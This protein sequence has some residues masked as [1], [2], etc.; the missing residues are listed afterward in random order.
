[1]H[2]N[3]QFFLVC[4]VWV[5]I[6]S[7]LSGTMR[8][9][10][11]MYPEKRLLQ[12]ETP[13]RGSFGEQIIA[14]TVLDLQTINPCINADDFTTR[15]LS[16]V[17]DSLAYIN[18]TSG[19][20]E[21]AIATTWQS[22]D[23]FI[24][25][26]QLDSN[27]KWHDGT[28][29]SADDVVFSYNFILNPDAPLRQSE[30]Y[31]L[32]KWERIPGANDKNGTYWEAVQKIDE[33]S[34]KFVLVKP[35]WNFALT[36]LNLPI[37]KKE[38]WK[39]HWNDAA[40][41]N[42]DLNPAT[43]ASMS[44]GTGPYILESWKPG[45]EIIL[46]PNANYTKE[47]GAG[48][49]IVKYPTYQTLLDAVKNQSVEIVFHPIPEEYIPEFS[50]VST[51]SVFT[52][53]SNVLT[54]LGFNLEKYFEGYDEGTGYS[55]RSAPDDPITYP[56]KV[57]GMDAGFNFRMAVAHAFPYSP[58]KNEF[59]N[60]VMWE[61]SLVQNDT[62]YYN[63]SV[64]TYNFNLSQASSVLNAANYKDLDGDGWR[65]DYSGREMG[66]NGVIKI[67]I[68]NRNI[69][70]LQIG[71][72]LCANLRAIGINADTSPI[73]VMN[74]RDYD[75][76]LSEVYT[77]QDMEYLY[78]LINSKYDYTDGIKNGENLWRYRNPDVD[79]LTNAMLSASEQ[80]FVT[81]IKYI[82]GVIST[83]LPVLP[84]YSSIVY[85]IA[86]I[87]R[88]TF[89]GAD[90]SILLKHNIIS[91]RHAGAAVVEAYATPHHLNELCGT[92]SEIIVRVYDAEGK[93]IAG[94]PVSARVFPANAIS[95]DTSSKTTD[96][97]G[98]TFFTLSIT[99]TLNSLQMLEIVCSATAFGISKKFYIVL[100]PIE[101]RIEVNSSPYLKGLAN[102]SCVFSIN[103][104]QQG[105]P[106]E[107]AFARIIY[108]SDKSISVPI[109]ENLSDSNGNAA[110]V[111]FITHDYTENTP[112]QL[113]FAVSVYGCEE[114]AYTV[115]LVITVPGSIELTLQ[116]LCEGV[117][118]KTGRGEINASVSAEGSPVSN[119]SLKC[120]IMDVDGIFV[121]ESPEGITDSSGKAVF[122]VSM[123]D[124]PLKTRFF[125]FFV[126][127]CTPVYHGVVFSRGILK[128]PE[129]ISVVPSPPNINLK[130]ENGRFSEVQISVQTEGKGLKNAQVFAWKGR[131]DGGLQILGMP[132]LTDT[133]GTVI[134]GLRITRDYLYD[135]GLNVVIRALFWG[136]DASCEL[137][138][139][140]SRVSVP[141]VSI[142]LSR[143]E[144]EGVTGE[145]VTAGV[146]VEKDGNPVQNA[147]VALVLSSK[148]N[149]TVNPQTATT[150]SS[151]NAKFEITVTANFT[152][153]T[154]LSVNAK[155]IINTSTYTGTA[156][157]LRIYPAGTVI[158]YEITLILSN[159]E[160][161]GK[162]GESLLITGTVKKSGAGVEGVNFTV[163][164]VGSSDVYIAPQVYTTDSNG[165]AYFTLTITR[166]IESEVVIKLTGK[167]AIGGKDYLS[168]PVS[169]KVKPYVQQKTP[170]FEFL[171][172]ILMLVAVFLLMF[173]GKKR[174]YR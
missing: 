168:E 173:I 127:V 125:G 142:N 93:P 83:H 154:N 100:E 19:N 74:I 50:Q 169:V 20:A 40:T 133:E 73:A 90:E 39:E 17:Y 146:H 66:H 26:V 29:V 51:F 59:T 119:L 97:N 22:S 49:K 135:A 5:L 41:W 6:A 44:V 113:T 47:V 112:L 67:Y 99:E 68:Q 72:E 57:G 170:G 33:R 131:A 53:R 25:T 109:G 128:I 102:N 118:W 143:N 23:G 150:D 63:A 106:V 149:L 123:A 52:H 3:K 134:L 71:M 159:T 167:A 153:E 84:I 30:Y 54:I 172:S 60:R 11:G 61:N 80:N 171:P 136:R 116:A 2:K 121:I 151:G 122:A 86:D 161:T 4:M 1:M 94:T 157:N 76:F 162:Q 36:I 58:V 45:K 124:M 174:L 160:I 38:I 69:I 43:G 70:N 98:C 81:T 37:L 145:R 158:E 130:G 144:I 79:N 91:M 89:A 115:T 85:E 82:Q 28:L 108:V 7:M 35:I 96:D 10:E 56:S 13:V 92:L 32:L 62:Q 129:T 8:S 114:R 152:K 46:T 55:P 139:T 16:L 24:W 65:E 77:A 137:N 156:V 155:V 148:T 21:P 75:L 165:N 126:V 14:G 132:E 111:L 140:I 138:I 31:S 12:G 27:T 87:G 105:I 101:L 95:L 163:L 103:I 15:V 64:N 120:G 48:I 88:I 166:N 110:F 104:T 78:K 147:D 18:T 164:L 34:V 9:A 117:D 141:V 42:L 107:R